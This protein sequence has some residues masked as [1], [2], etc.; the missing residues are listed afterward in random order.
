MIVYGG[1]TEYIGDVHPSMESLL[2]NNAY[3]GEMKLWFS[4]YIYI[5]ITNSINLLTNNHLTI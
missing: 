2:T 4:I 3:I 5:L 1:F